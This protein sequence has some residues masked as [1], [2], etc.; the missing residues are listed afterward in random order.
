MDEAL[1]FSFV[2]HMDI[3]VILYTQGKRKLERLLKTMSL[4]ISA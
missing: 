1:C 3:E 4:V 2:S